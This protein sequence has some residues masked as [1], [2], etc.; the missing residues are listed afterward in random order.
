[1]DPKS[2]VSKSSAKAKTRPTKPP[3]YLSP[4]FER[5][6]PELIKRP[7]WVLWYQEWTG[8]KWTKRPIQPSGY[9]A[10]SIN[11]KHW[12]SFEEVKRAYQVVV[13]RG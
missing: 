3:K 8:T 12:S 5:M 6:P 10:S 9:H 2:S 4:I 11:P 1:M 7:N 13:K